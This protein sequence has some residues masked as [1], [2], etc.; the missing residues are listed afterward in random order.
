MSKR[1]MVSI[2]GLLVMALVFSGVAQ[3]QTT[4]PKR[5]AAA[6]VSTET[7]SIGVIT[8]V[9]ATHMVITHKVK[10]KDESMTLILTPET[11]KEGA[12][13]AGSRVSFRYRMENNDRVATTVRA[14]ATAAK[15]K[16]PQT[17]AK[18]S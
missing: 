13:E 17:K 10:G 18:K 5:Q 7:T 15:A 14:T 4:A 12:L 8:S 9:D 11:K 3:A 1:W 2:W 6:K 16:T